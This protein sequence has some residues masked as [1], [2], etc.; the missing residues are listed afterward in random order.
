MAVTGISFIQSFIDRSV[1]DIN[2][3]KTV[4][5]KRKALDKMY[6]ASKDML[7]EELRVYSFNN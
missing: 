2:Q 6:I 4:E 3:L 1:E 7:E 5:E